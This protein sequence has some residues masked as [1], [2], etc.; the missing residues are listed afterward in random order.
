[1]AMGIGPEGLNP[2]YALLYFSVFSVVSV[3][4]IPAMVLSARRL[5]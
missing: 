4:T 2:S 3:A 1:M 5:L